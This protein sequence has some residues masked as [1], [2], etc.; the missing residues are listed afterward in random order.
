MCGLKGMRNKILR[1]KKSGEKFYRTA[2]SSLK[3]RVKK[4]LTEKT[5][6][7]KKGKNEEA[8]P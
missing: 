4:K 7:Y 3:R 1:R 8:T 5:N 6:W 2:K